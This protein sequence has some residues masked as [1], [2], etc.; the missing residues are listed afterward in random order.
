MPHWS[1]I[2]DWEKPCTEAMLR[3]ER[4]DFTSLDP[5]RLDEAVKQMWTEVP[6]HK[7]LVA[8]LTPLAATLAAF[9]GVLMIP[10][11]FGENALA[12]ASISELLGAMGLAAMSAV[13]AGGQNSRNVGQQAARQQIAD[14]QAV[15]CDVFGI[16]R[17]ANSLEVRVA[18]T[19]QVLPNAQ[20]TSRGPT[21]PTLEVYAV[22][23]EF[24]QELQRTI[25]RSGASRP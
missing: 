19:K 4:D 16:A 15:L 5:R 3:F 17:P 14:F 2:K 18:G 25:P 13:W 22:R 23:D 7:K 6:M 20:I 8:G 12:A 11:D 1:T 9:G 21:G 24:Q 10:I